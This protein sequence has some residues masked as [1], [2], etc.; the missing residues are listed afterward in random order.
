MN[1]TEKNERAGLDSGGG[2]RIKL[3]WFYE[4]LNPTTGKN[5]AFPSRVGLSLE[6]KEC[7][8]SFSKNETRRRKERE[9]EKSFIVL[10]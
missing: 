4:T 2:M 9:E 3:F 10:L 6:G 1:Y 8:P 7:F 5:E